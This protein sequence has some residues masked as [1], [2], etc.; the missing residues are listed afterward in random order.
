LDLTINIW[1]ILDNTGIG[2]KE[3]GERKNFVS[4]S[5][6]VCTASREQYVFIAY[7]RKVVLK[8]QAVKIPSASLQVEDRPA[9]NLTCAR[10]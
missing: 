3:T 10:L 6:D 5:I 9:N 8:M 2:R 7:L 1:W 4:H